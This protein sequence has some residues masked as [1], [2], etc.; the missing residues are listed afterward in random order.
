MDQTRTTTETAAGHGNKFLGRSIPAD[1]VFKANAHLPEHQRDAVL[2]LHSVY[3]ERDL[4]MAD[5]GK[6]VDLSPASISLLFNGKF[7][8]NLE[9]AIESI[10]GYFALEVR[11]KTAAELP[12]VETSQ[13]AKIFR[14]CKL[15]LSWESWNFVFGDGQK[16]KSEALKEAARRHPENYIYVEMPAGAA[17][18]CF[19]SKIA[20]ALRMPMISPLFAMRQRVIDYFC[21]RSETPNGRLLLMVDE[22]HRC[23][24]EGVLTKAGKNSLDF[25]KEL[26]NESKCGVVACATNTFGTDKFFEQFFRRGLLPPFIIGDPNRTDLD[27]FAK[28]VGLPPS[29]GQARQLEEKLIQ[30]DALGK[31]IKMLKMGAQAAAN[32]NQPLTWSH[33]LSFSYVADT[34]EGGVK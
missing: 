26:A 33:V 24:P 18:S 19:L 14:A 17:L 12:F 20:K 34:M 25:V 27:K 13:T 6:L 32:Q 15:A 29:S 8:G 30:K 9:N 4:S 31:W 10:N 21:V 16:G 22:C 5:V 2:K 23:M 28:A 7:N 3:F 1:F 11:R